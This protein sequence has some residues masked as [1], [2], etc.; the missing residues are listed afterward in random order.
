MKGR[1]RSRGRLE[2][3]GWPDMLCRWAATVSCLR[4]TVSGQAADVMSFGDCEGVLQVVGASRGHTTSGTATCAGA[5]GQPVGRRQG[6]G[7]ARGSCGLWSGRSRRDAHG[8]AHCGGK[9]GA[10]HQWRGRQRK[11]GAAG[12]GGRFKVAV[13]LPS[14][15]AYGLKYAMERAGGGGLQRR[16][17]STEPEAQLL[18]LLWLE[19]RE[20]SRWHVLCPIPSTPVEYLPP[21]CPL[22]LGAGR[23]VLN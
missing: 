7:A 23:Y 18:L 16:L 21:A 1:S 19:A 9:Q 12:A 14:P 22:H 5:A 17:R 8:S 10:Q 13:S 4:R 2:P 20:A 6:G 11:R 15:V 3:V